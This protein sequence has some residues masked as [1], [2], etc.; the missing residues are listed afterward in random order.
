MAELSDNKRKKVPRKQR[1]AELK[2]KKASGGMLTWKEAYELRKVIVWV[3][4]VFVG[5]TILGI[6]VILE[7]TKIIDI[8]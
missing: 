7:A 3:A 8:F 6:V 2:A 1:V 5:W 4:A